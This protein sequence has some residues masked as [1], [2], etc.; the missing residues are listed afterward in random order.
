MTSFRKLVASEEKALESLRKEWM[1][2][3]KEITAV[4][5]EVLGVKGL[6]ELMSGKMKGELVTT[7][8]RERAKELEGIKTKFLGEVETASKDALEGMRQGEKVCS[9]CCFPCFGS[10]LTMGNGRS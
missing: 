1:E 4:A 7:E 9:G 5:M 6:E 8:Q 2:V 3:Q 10:V